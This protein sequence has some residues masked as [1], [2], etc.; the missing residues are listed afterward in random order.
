MLFKT[1]IVILGAVLSLTVLN[2]HAEMVIGTD[3]SYA[4]FEFFDE[5]Q[6]LSGFDIELMNAICAQLSEKCTYVYM[7]FNHLAAQL[8]LGQLT[9]VM[10]AFMMTDA[11]THQFAFTENYYNNPKVLIG[12][13]QTLTNIAALTGKTVG[14]LSKSPDLNY[15][16]TEHPNIKAR[17]LDAIEEAVL[18]LDKG[19]IDAVILD[20]NAAKQYLRK[21]PKM[22]VIGE[23]ILDATHFGMGFGIGFKKDNTVTR[24]K[25][26]AALKQLKTSGEYQQIY[27][28]WFNQ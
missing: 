20:S 5:N 2:S 3:P 1:K 11:R 22:F 6:K 7:P 8:K 16:N 9:T 10:S 12:T 14:A 26:E 15:L 18:E 4:P 24:D 17:P 28:K 23:P 21:Y 13:D 19:T 27:D 25:V